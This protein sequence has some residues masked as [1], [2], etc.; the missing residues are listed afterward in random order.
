MIS[1]KKKIKFA[2]LGYGNRARKYLKYIEEHPDK[3][4]ITAIVEINSLL[5]KSA[6][7]KYKEWDILFF[8]NSS[9]FFNKKL[10]IDAIIIATPDDSHFKLSMKAISMHYNI[11]LEKP[12]AQS[13]EQCNQIYEYAYQNKVKVF[14]CYV[15]RYH[16][17]FKKLKEIL[18]SKELGEIISIDHTVNVGIDRM[19]HTFVRGIWSETKKS[20]PIIL[21]KCC[22]DIDLLLWL[23][24][25]SSD[26]VHSTGSLEYFCPKNA[27]KGSGLRCSEC[28]IEP[29]CRFSAI[30]LYQ[31][32]KEWINNFIQQG[33]GTTEEILNEVINNSPYGRCVFQ[34]T[35][36]VVDNQ[37]VKIE[38]KN[39][40]EIQLRLNCI[41]EKDNRETVVKCTNGWLS[42]DENYIKFRKKNE[43]EEKVYD[44]RSYRNM[45]LHANADIAIVEDFIENLNGNINVD[46]P[47]IESS[48]ESHKICFLAEKRRIKEH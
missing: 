30:D 45:P 5:L 9:D 23:A 31:K 46:S 33:N 25:S 43:T 37:E 35:N 15:L 8:N 1:T 36:D 42:A 17:Y 41:T 32:R 19:T 7:E 13:L 40:I 21:S 47:T 26:N 38:L 18:S 29:Q 14:V 3:A 16:P 20:N 27:P 10:D 22:H 12:I 6:Q 2:I 4:E 11:L 28:S 34:C 48:L 39:G 24:E 44:F